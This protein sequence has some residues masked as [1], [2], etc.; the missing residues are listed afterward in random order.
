MPKNRSRRHRSTLRRA[1]K[2]RK[3]RR[4]R[5]SERKQRGGG[6]KEDLIELITSADNFDTVLQFLQGME[7]PVYHANFPKKDGES[8]VAIIVEGEVADDNVPQKMVVITAKKPA[9]TF[10]EVTLEATDQKKPKDYLDQYSGN[11][12]PAG[13]EYTGIRDATRD[14]FDVGA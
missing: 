3:T 2:A 1:H 10:T 14:L 8:Y 5:K 7:A 12:L 4:A 11:I 6:H 9:A 13:P